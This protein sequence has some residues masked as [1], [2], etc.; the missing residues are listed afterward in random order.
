MVINV[1]LGNKG[2][3]V[4]QCMDSEDPK[5]VSEKFAKTYQLNEKI[6]Q[7]VFNLVTNKIAQ[8]NQ[9]KGLSYY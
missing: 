6:Q 4:L 1:D 3:Q 5:K 8:M 7:Q 9:Y 2:F